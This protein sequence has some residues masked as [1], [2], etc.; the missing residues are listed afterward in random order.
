M[1]NTFRFL[2]GILIFLFIFLYDLIKQNK[3]KIEQ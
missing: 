3:E 2:A 1:E